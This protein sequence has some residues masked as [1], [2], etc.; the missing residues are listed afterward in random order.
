MARAKRLIALID[1][2]YVQEFFIRRTARVALIRQREIIEEVL[3]CKKKN[4]C[5]FSPL[6]HEFVLLDALCIVLFGAFLHYFVEYCV[7]LITLPHI[8]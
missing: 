7:V 8:K 1:A 3:D 2:K 6:Q 5:N 4:A